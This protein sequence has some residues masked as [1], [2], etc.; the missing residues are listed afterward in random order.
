ME[1]GHVSRR[2]ERV[3]DTRLHANPRASVAHASRARHAAD[4]RGRGPLA[5]AAVE[6]GPTLVANLCTG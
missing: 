6:L 5:G 4:R 2:Q 3:A 1:K